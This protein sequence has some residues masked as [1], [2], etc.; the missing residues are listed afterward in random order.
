MP[1]VMAKI[2][3]VPIT[4]EQFERRLSQSRSMNPSKYDS[5]TGEE[6]ERAV[7]RTLNA[8]IIRE[9]EYQ[10]ALRNGIGVNDEEV[11]K[12]FQD[13]RRRYTAEG[14]FSEALKEFHITP[15]KW[16]EEMKRTM[17]IRKLEDKMARKIPI[18]ENEIN[19]YLKIDKEKT[20]SVETGKEKKEKIRW[21]IQQNRWG[22]VR[23]AWLKGLAENADIWRWS[24]SGKDLFPLPGVDVTN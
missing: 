22:E 16:K 21:I 20:T 3:G 1:E 13:L 2:N 7:L 17:A 24:P 10:E 19:E 14:E 4:R 12:E 23:K 8:M 9:L 11:E 18:S 5:M 15:E 6:K